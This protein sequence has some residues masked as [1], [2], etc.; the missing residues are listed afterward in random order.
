MSTPE[1]PVALAS[2]QGAA[3]LSSAARLAILLTILAVIA[4]DLSAIV[5]N[6]FELD[7]LSQQAATSAAEAWRSNP[8]AEAVEAAVHAEIPDDHDVRIE[9]IGVDE[10]TVWVTLERRPP[11]IALDRLPTVGDRLDV[12]VTQ[13]ALLRPQGL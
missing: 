4:F 6:I 12:S 5:V 13:R 7:D 9:A 1:H 8:R 2:E 10:T 3:R 11:V